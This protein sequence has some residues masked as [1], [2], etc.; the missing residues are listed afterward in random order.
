MANSTLSLGEALPKEMAR[1]R[2]VSQ[3]YAEFRN[4]P[5]VNVEFTIAG[6]NA[7]LSAAEKAMVEGDTVAM[8]SA[9]QSLQGF[10]V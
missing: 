9:Y 2:E 5:G 1:V 3:Q 4:T 8:L 6:M 7:S 10:D